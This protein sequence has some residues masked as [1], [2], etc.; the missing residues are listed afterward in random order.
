M[1]RTP[2]TQSGRSVRNG[3]RYPLVAA[4][5]VVGAVAGILLFAG[6]PLAARS[7]AAI[8]ALS[9]AGLEFVRMIGRLKKGIV[10]VD[11]LAVIAI[12][13]TVLVGELLAAL[14][15]VLMLTGG[16]A[17]EDYAQSRAEREMRALID[18]SPRTAHRVSPDGERVTVDIGVSEVAV[19]DVLLVRPSEVV[20][21][22]GLLSP[23]IDVAEF[24]ESSLTGESLPVLRRGG[25]Q[26]FSGS[27]NGPTAIRMTASR[28]A[29]HSQY[30]SIVLLVSEASA[31]PAPVVRLADR[32]ALPFTGVALLI[33]AVAWIL[34]GD[35][36]RFAEVLVLATPCPLI[37]AAPIAFMAGMSRGAKTGIIVKGGAVLE[38]LSRVRTVVFDKTGTLTYGL[39][40]ISDVRAEP[41][42]TAHQI[43]Q[44]AAS[45]EQYSSHVLANSIVEYVT[46]AGLQL[47]DAVEAEETAA[48]GVSARVGTDEVHVG[49]LGFIRDRAP[50]AKA[51][52]L[53]AGEL[54]IYVAV[55]NQFAGAIIARDRLRGNAR[56]AIAEL[57]R[58]GAEHMVM[59]TGDAYATAASIADLAGISDVRAGCLPSGKVDAV[60][61]MPDRPVMMVGD[62]VNDAPVLAAADVGIAMGA[63]GATAASESADVVILVDDLAKAVDAVAIGQDSVR[64]AL[65]SIWI[66]IVL[67][68]V[69]MLVAAFG[70]IPAAVGAGIQEAVDLICILNAL[71]ALSSPPRNR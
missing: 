4:T 54:A 2:E 21:V 50:R 15:I 65:Q 41:P 32:F 58:R 57:Q 14:I 31:H 22:D 59:L 44:L 55:N 53:A 23:E 61:T 46:A 52:T 13:S 24:D 12:V 11:V 34:S 51:T 9:I 18:R 71:R 62:G 36:V 5:I 19:G 60:A 64:I 26:L 66:G 56:E 38:L 20:P 70:V 43:L 7:I 30:Q 40:T 48:G 35:P 6:V 10:G 25:E 3:L 17:L 28:D 45:A 1:T 16:E 49:T 63:R 42:F 8:Y 33:G 47:H 29:A 69:L 67:S 68:V 27:I 37:I 39:P